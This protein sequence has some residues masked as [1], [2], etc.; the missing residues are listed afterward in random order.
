M[1]KQFFLSTIFAT[2]ALFS[3]AQAPTIAILNIDSNLATN[4]SITAPL[5]NI[6]G[7]LWPTKLQVREQD[8]TLWISGAIIVYG[9]NNPSIL[10][11][12]DSLNADRLYY[13]RAISYNLTYTDSFVSNIKTC[14]TKPNEQPISVAYIGIA[15]GLPKSGI[16][17]IASSIGLSS[18]VYGVNGGTGN[19]ITD[20]TYV[21]GNVT[22]TVFVANNPGQIVPEILLVIK[23]VFTNSSNIAAANSPSF[24]APNYSNP[25][26]V[27]GTITKTSSSVTIPISVTSIGNGGIPVL[28][29]LMKDTSTVIDTFITITAPGNYTFSRTGLKSN[30]W[31]STMLS[32]L[33]PFGMGDSTFHLIKTNNVNPPSATIQLGAAGLTI[34]TVN[35][36]TNTNGALDSS[37]IA[38]TRYYEDNVLVDSVLGAASSFTRTNRASSTIYYGKVQ[39]VNLAGLSAWSTTV[40][41]TMQHVDPNQSPYIYDLFADGTDLRVTGIYFGASPGNTSTPRLMCRDMMTGFVDT[42]TVATG[43]TGTGSIP[44]YIFTNRVGNHRYQVT[45]FD[46][47]PAG[48]VWGNTREQN[49]PPPSDVVIGGIVQEQVSTTA[50]MLGIHVFGSGEGNDSPIL[51]LWLYQNN[52]QI[53]SVFSTVVNSGMFDYEYVWDNLQPSTEYKVI[54]EISATGSATSSTFGFFYTD[55]MSGLSEIPQITETQAV[56]VCNIMGQVV[57]N[58]EY[59]TVHTSL[60]GSQ[61][62]FLFTPLG[63]DGLPSG[64][65]RKLFVQ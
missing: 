7:G 16:K 61:E 10:I 4:Q 39:V 2:L 47:S 36:T 60:L 51:K 33:N 12:M 64:T 42:G 34:Y 41:I 8:S 22:D 26:M 1:K 18:Y 55:A 9:S 46:D 49:M 56:R 30:H 15:P 40:S 17:F 59:K 28:R 14:R 25:T 57:T 19:P 5:L 38:V 6:S 43:L 44:E 48:R 23:S 45:V 37:A 31:H 58:G 13:V 20:T 62:L 50:T 29:I 24:T 35:V 65:T 52:V 27:V 54:A 11:T 21:T 3:M 32:L 53:G 63:D